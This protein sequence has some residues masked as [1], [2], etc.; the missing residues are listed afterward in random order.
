MSTGKAERGP[1]RAEPSPRDAVMSLSRQTRLCRFK[2]N[3]ATAVE[4]RDAV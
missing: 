1:S 3:R 2:R 4:H